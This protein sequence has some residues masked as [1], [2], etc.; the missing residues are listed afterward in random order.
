MTLNSASKL[1]PSVTTYRRIDPDEVQHPSM[2]LG[3]DYWRQQK[4]G[5]LFPAR[6]DIRPRDITGA[7]QHLSL[8]KVSGGD[9]H[10]RIVGD[11]VVRAYDVTLQ[12]RSL[13]D[14]ARTSPAFGAIAIP[15][16]QDVVKN[17]TP[18]AISGT[19]GHDAQRANFTDYE[20]LFLPLGPDD[21]TVDHILIF[22]DHISRGFG[23]HRP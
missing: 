16:M 21:A 23:P 14:I 6:D 17:K 5:R 1:L 10:Y 11:A 8:L 20:V 7:L 3:L 4:D 9:F 12:H 13:S 19:T 18:I 15:L 22:S 2:R